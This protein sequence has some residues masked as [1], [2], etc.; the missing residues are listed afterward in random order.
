MA[1]KTSKKKVGK[2]TARRKPA[3]LEDLPEGEPLAQPLPL[4]EV[5]GQANAL[6]TLTRSLESDRLHHA[7]IFHGPKGVGKFTTA[8][9]F[10]AML[11][12]PTT[13][14][15]L[16]GELAPDPDSQ[17]QQ[18]IREAGH[19]DLHV[20]YKELARYSQEASVRNSKLTSIP[21]DVVETHLLKPA[22]LAP[23]SD[24][25]VG[26][27]A[28][29]VFIVDEA[30]MLDPRGAGVVQN[31]LL[32]TLEEPPSGTVIILVTDSE[33]RLLPTIR[34]RC[35]RVSFTAL[36]DKAM[37][38]WLDSTEVD[39]SKSDVDW[40]VSYAEGS[41]GRLLRAADAKLADWARHLEPMLRLA[42]AGK[43]SPELGAKMTSLSED[44]AKA[45][46]AHDARRSKEAANREAA[47][48]LF[49][50]LS[51]R[52]RA[53]MRQGENLDE[54]IRAI[55]AIAEAEARLSA[56]VSPQVVYDWLAA[57]IAAPVPFVTRA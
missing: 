7:W 11:L 8:L 9:A 48:M 30:H 55:D 5:L 22:H 23:K 15:G 53:Q 25:S 1:K 3:V 35:Q 33:E 14:K 41:P 50:V 49:S 20:V 44:W 26:A 38:E 6:A 57:V 19:P 13:D 4:S 45:H 52:A 40:L 39:I 31:A 32:K 46:V 28:R 56:N 29:K 18:I 37:G 27:A 21:K 24:L 47:A 2:K 17:T 16:S 10:G 12:D 36:D 54:S 34:S 43:L 42:D 51:T